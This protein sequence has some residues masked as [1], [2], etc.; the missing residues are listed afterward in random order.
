MEELALLSN[1][2]PEDLGE[3]PLTIIGCGAVGRRVAEGF[4]RWGASHII[5]RDFDAVERHNVLGRSAQG[6]TH[7]DIGLSKVHALA[8]SLCT[9]NPELKIETQ[10]SKLSDI[11]TLGG[12]VCACVDDMDTR[13]LIRDS[14]FNSGE[15]CMLCEARITDISGRVFALNPHNIEHQAR[16]GDLSL[17]YS[18]A[19]APEGGCGSPLMYPLTAHDAARIMMGSVFSFLRRERGSPESLIN[20]TRFISTPSFAIVEEEIW[21]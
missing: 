8:S 10:H 4:A 9:Y 19:E 17:W 15:A 1:I 12:F 3:R 7:S 13:I 20:M 11:E 21:C 16:Y 2:E 5:L 14:A 18:N 6:Y